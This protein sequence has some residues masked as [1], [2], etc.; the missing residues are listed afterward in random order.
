MRSVKSVLLL[1][2]VVGACSDTSGPGFIAGKWAQDFSFPGSYFEMNLT[3]NAGM[4]SGTGD[5]C[6]EAGPCGTVAVTGTT[7][8]GAVQLDLAITATLPSGIL[9]S[10][11]HFDGHLTTFASLRG[12]LTVE[13]PNQAAVAVGQVSYHRE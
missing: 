6:A 7:S 3:N 5:W 2:I 9:Y 4:I 10:I 12:L 11:Q 8:G 13:S 1:A